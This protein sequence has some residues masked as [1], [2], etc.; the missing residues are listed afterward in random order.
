M[1]GRVHHHMVR[2]IGRKPRLREPRR[3]RADVEHNGPCCDPVHLR[4]GLRKI[5]EC[6]IELHQSE[7][8]AFDPPLQRKTRN[9]STCPKLDDPFARM[10]RD[11]GSQKDR[12]M[13]RTMPPPELA[14]RE[15]PCK[16][17]VHGQIV[18]T[19]R[20][21]SHRAIRIPIRLRS[22]GGARQYCRSH[23]QGCGGES[24]PPTLP[25]RSYW[26]PAGDA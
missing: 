18:R 7:I 9:P 10:R 14:K 15:P 8:D 1:K 12:I 17:G 20:I 2:M 13:P 11:G 22:T 4:I 19:S 24:L 16:K 26:H 3:R 25:A 23:A 5:N 6:G 21:S